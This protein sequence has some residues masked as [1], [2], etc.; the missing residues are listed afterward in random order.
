MADAQAQSCNASS[1]GPGDVVF[2]LNLTV[3]PPSM[4]GY[5]LSTDVNATLYYNCA[6]FKYT[7]NCTTATIGPG[8]LYANGSIWRYW[9][10]YDVPYTFSATNPNLYYTLGNDF[11]WD[12][13]VCELGSCDAP[14]LLSPDVMLSMMHELNRNDTDLMNHD[15]A[16]RLICRF[17]ICAGRYF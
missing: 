17:W 13:Y 6:L 1:M 3:I 4:S 5:F 12:S 11:T 15:W 10:C 8:V 2:H 14:R 9:A 16:C 7:Y